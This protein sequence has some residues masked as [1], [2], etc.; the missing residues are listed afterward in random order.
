M[1]SAFCSHNYF[2]IDESTVIS[3]AGCREISSRASA[4]AVPSCRCGMRVCKELRAFLLGR[5]VL[6]LEHVWWH[7]LSKVT[8][9]R[10]D[11]IVFIWHIFFVTS[12]GDL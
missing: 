3:R 10:S 9:R 8:I 6:V 7:L 1:Q 11:Q 12:N 5:V 4:T 2:I